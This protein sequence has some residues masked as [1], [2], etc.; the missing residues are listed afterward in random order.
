[1][2]FMGHEEQGGNEGVAFIYDFAVVGMHQRG[3]WFQ[4]GSGV[5]KRE[6]RQ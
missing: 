3:E 4:S 2:W 6:T 1:M 5:F